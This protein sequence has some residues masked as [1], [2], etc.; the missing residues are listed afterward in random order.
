M[1]KEIMEKISQWKENKEQE[2]DLP[3][4]VTRD[5]VLRSLRR[6]R[7]VQREEQEK[8]QLRKDV[9]Q[10]KLNKFRELYGIKKEMQEKKATS[11]P[12]LHQDFNILHDA[13]KKK[14]G[15]PSWL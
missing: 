1:L 2:Q 14:K 12:I 7:R 3:D 6:E 15:K 5:K 9:A 13:P 8:I 10:Y 11:K 4:D